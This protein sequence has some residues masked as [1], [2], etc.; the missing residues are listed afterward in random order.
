MRFGDQEV[1]ETFFD[2]KVAPA[3][4][5]KK[6]YVLEVGQHVDEAPTTED[7]HE[8]W[9][10]WDGQPIP[11]GAALCRELESA[12]EWIFFTETW[13]GA[14][15]LFDAQL[16]RRPMEEPW[17]E[18]IE[19]LIAANRGR[20]GG[21]PDVIGQ[22]KDG[23]VVLCELKARVSKDRLQS[24]QHDFANAA[25]SLEGQAVDLMVVVWG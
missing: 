7:Q 20:I 21:F 19:K 12:M 10:V 17:S 24:N 18:V 3:T 15:R 11:A 9:V 4:P 6:L 1:D 25:M 5:M 16:F 13:G 8:H 2:W 23:T 14:M 22:R